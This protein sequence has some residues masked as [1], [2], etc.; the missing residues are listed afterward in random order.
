VTG[1]PPATG[2]RPPVTAERLTGPS[3]R[4]AGRPRHAHPARAMLALFLLAGGGLLLEIA[5]TRVLS[6]QLFSNL[7][8]LVLSVAILG[9]AVGAAL[10]TLLPRLLAPARLSVWTAAGG[11]AALFLAYL[12]TIGPALA[13][14]AMTRALL[15]PVAALPYLFL[16]LAVT[17]I[18]ANR[19][20]SSPR[21][22]LA[23]LAGAGLGALLAVPALN[24][25]GGAG[26]MLLASAALALS[27]LPLAHGRRLA[28]PAAAFL[29]ALLAL[30]VPLVRPAVDL[31][32]LLASKPAGEPLRAGGSVVASRWDAFARTDLVHLPAANR[33][34]IYLDGA[35]GSLVPDASSPESWLSDAGALAFAVDPPDQAFLIGPGGGLDIALA[36][37]FGTGRIVAAEVNRSAVTLTR[38]LAGHAGDLYG[39]G[40]EVVIDDGR[41][42]L[43][44]LGGT[45][46]LILL[47]QVVSQAA[48]ARGLALV[49]NGLYTVEAFG[50]YLDHL[51]ADGRLALKLYDELTLTRALLTATTA[52]AERGEA[53]ATAARHLFA[54]LDTRASPPVPLLLVN[55]EPLTDEQAV[56]WA[57]VAEGRGLSLLFVPGLLSPPALAELLAGRT[58]IASLVKGAQGVDIR[59]TS[60][61]RPFF[62]Q[63]ERGLPRAVRPL[64]A[65]VAGLL[66]A[67]LAFAGVRGRR[68]PAE[69]RLAPPLFAA[70][71]A[72]FMLFEIGV[73][74]T[75]Q[76][77]IGRPALALSAVLAALLLG[78][79]AGSGLAGRCPPGREHGWLAAAA[80]CA[81][82]S[83]L[84]WLTLWPTAATL[85]RGLAPLQAALGTAL[86]ILPL[87]LPL[88]IPFALALRSLGR[89]GREPVALA[90]TVNGVASVAGAVAATALGLVFGLRLVAATAACCYLVAA[91]LG[92][93]LAHRVREEEVQRVPAAEL[94]GR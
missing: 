78:A 29:L 71:G 45:F 16:G 84:A 81:V 22:Y 82:L 72:G 54:V 86:A 70:L 31:D 19:S 83:N 35:A 69:V 41:S 75:T 79:A 64:S 56:R 15:F 3:A 80:G 47:S 62:Y 52:L 10:A 50:E 30:A 14:E 33:Y 40:T 85:M 55:R 66:I 92:L 68:S 8:Y 2:K 24:A 6:V 61:D 53:P 11:L 5:L 51:S 4:P 23:D 44:R 58:G 57:R 18:F 20:E 13:G 90:W 36:R 43:R 28:L 21:L 32:A 37:E 59:P 26:G 93:I 48:E 88:G 73:L 7:S 87:A 34:L 74:Q 49:E 27:G 76:L 65:A 39:D 46:D 9:L 60:D 63:F 94:T 89:H 12:A 91:A 17:G 42:A 67:A 25:V 38:S 1:G 77:L